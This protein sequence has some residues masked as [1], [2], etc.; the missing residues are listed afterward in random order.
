MELLLFSAFGQQNG[1]QS[2]GPDKPNEPMKNSNEKMAYTSALLNNRS[3]SPMQLE[4]NKEPA[5]D[6]QR[7]AVRE[8]LRERANEAA[9]ESGLREARGNSREQARDK[10]LSNLS[11]QATLAALV[12]S[13]SQFNKQQLPGQLAGNQLTGNHFPG[14]LSSQLSPGLSN[15]Q[16]SGSP[17]HSNSLHPGGQ[18]ISNINNQLISNQFSGNHHPGNQLPSQ[19]SG[20]LSGQLSDGHPLANQQLHSSL[21]FDNVKNLLLT[22]QRKGD[23]ENSI[24]SGGFQN[25]LT[26]LNLSVGSA[27]NESGFQPN[28]SANTT[29]SPNWRPIRTNA[30]NI[31]T[32]AKQS[33]PASWIDRS[34]LGKVAAQSMYPLFLLWP[35]LL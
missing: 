9:R 28:A 25:L 1:Q 18:F 15:Q 33:G 6:F 8:N 31:I 7:D 21:T 5:R 20:Q 4:A 34:K 17:A 14:S 11:K 30:Q 12:A 16:L 35:S 26:S 23:T 29:A 2:A 3:S 10:G 27:N 32:S 13:M 19:L 24:F 22:N